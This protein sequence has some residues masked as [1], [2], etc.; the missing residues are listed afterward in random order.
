M[1]SKQLSLHDLIR[2]LASFRSQ[3]PTSRNPTIIALH[4]RG[5]NEQDLIPNGL[6]LEINEAT[7][8]DKP[9]ILTHGEQDTMIRV[10]GARASRDQLQKLGVDL[11]YHEFQMGHS[12]SLESLAVISTWLK[13]QLG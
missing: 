1:A 4:G 13:K 8:K 6:D 2:F 3:E 5:S 9:L 7:V 12:V 10:D 11:D